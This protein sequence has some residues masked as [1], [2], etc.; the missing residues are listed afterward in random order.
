MMTTPNHLADPRH[1]NALQR[2]AGLHHEWKRAASLISEETDMSESL[3]C[4]SNDHSPSCGHPP[5]IERTPHLYVG[6]FEGACGDQWVFTFNR[7]TRTAEL[8]GGDVGWDEIHE[9]QYGHVDHLILPAEE[10][11]WL[12]ACWEAAAGA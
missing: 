8:R 10:A 1:R 5:T 3:L 11:L 7:Q 6:Y 12:A 4:V 9:V 2:P